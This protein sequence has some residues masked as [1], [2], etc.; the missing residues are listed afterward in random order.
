MARNDL[1]VIIS[2]ED[3]ASRQIEQLVDAY[4]RA[5]Q[6]LGAAAAPAARR[7]EVAFTGIDSSVGKMA[8]SLRSLTLPLVNELVPAF[9]AT[10]QQIAGVITSAAFLGGGIGAVAIAA[11]GLAGVLGGKLL[12]SMRS[13]EQTKLRVNEAFRTGEIQVTTQE[14]VRLKGEIE[15]LGRVR[16]RFAA[17]G[18]PMAVTVRGDV[19]GAQAPLVGQAARLR[20]AEERSAA[21]DALRADAEAT[22]TIIRGQIQERIRAEQALATLQGEN[23]L[24]TMD[25]QKQITGARIAALRQILEAEGGQT[26]AVS[27]RH[28][29]QQQ[30]IAA[31]RDVELRAIQETAA[32]RRR[33]VE[34]ELLDAGTRGE[35]LAQISREAALERQRV[36][37]KA[38]VDSR[39][40]AAAFA[41][42]RQALEEQFY[43]A[44]VALGEQSLQ[45]ELARQQKILQATEATSRAHI[46]AMGKIAALQT[47]IKGDLQAGFQAALPAA[48]AAGKPVDPLRSSIL[49]QMGLEQHRA[50]QQ[51]PSAF[52]VLRD[53]EADA[54]GEVSLASMQRAAD[55]A[56]RDRADV[57]DTLRRGGRVPRERLQGALA[58]PEQAPN[59]RAL[60][61]GFDPESTMANLLGPGRAAGTGNPFD[62]KGPD[63]ITRGIGPG[64]EPVFGVNRPDVGSP[65]ALQET[66]IPEQ[67]EA[68]VA[69]QTPR[70][71][72]VGKVAG[73]AF[74]KGF[75]AGGV[76][77][78]LAEDLARKIEEAV[79]ESLLLGAAQRGGF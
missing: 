69:Q 7:L 55:K 67:L 51:D 39:T 49:L 10:T 50:G 61:G 34:Q 56:A 16:D 27:Q 26:L 20:G 48:P 6:D 15:N 52:R 60:L 47:Q 53:E 28:E 75:L 18:G 59:L 22:A 8:R 42:E 5:F 40:A 64:G 14:L 46:E 71:Q 2:A 36:E 19:A 38:L 66:A 43:A 30:A 9:G 70:F 13:I 57:F 76:S 58:A 78:R 17:Q 35:R 65:F 29:L 68:A 54:R 11:S 73:E 31:M 3:R 62:A 32:A 1:K 4:G 37:D 33:A 25:L 44:K 77:G 79:V 12:E 23:A 45:A 63:V 72:Q 41:K 21:E 24:K 74:A